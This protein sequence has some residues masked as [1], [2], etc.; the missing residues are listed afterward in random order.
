MKEIDPWGSD[1]A[2]AFGE[3][4]IIHCNSHGRPHYTGWCTVPNREKVKLNSTTLEEAA[5]ECRV[6]GLWMY[7]DWLKTQEGK[8]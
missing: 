2:A 8:L 3:G 6:S 4:V 1:D 7:H 5:D